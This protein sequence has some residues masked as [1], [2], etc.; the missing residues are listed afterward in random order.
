MKKTALSFLAH[1]DDAE[2]LCA[3]T[4]IRLREAGWDV[5][6]AT[7]TAA[8]VGR[9]RGQ[10]STAPTAPPRAGGGGPDLRDYH[11]ST[12][13]TSSSCS[14]ATI[15]KTLDLFRRVCRPL[16][17]TR[18][19][20]IRTRGGHHARAGASFAYGSRTSRLPG[21]PTR[22]PPL[23]YCDPIAGSTRTA[24]R[25]SRRRSDVTRRRT[26]GDARC[27]SATRVARATT[28]YDYRRDEAPRR[29][30]RHAG[31][32]TYARR[33]ATPDTLPR[34]TA[35]RDVQALTARCM[36]ASPMPRV[37]S[38]C[39]ATSPRTIAAGAP[40]S[41]ECYYLGRGL[42]SSASRSRGNASATC[43]TPY[44]NGVPLPVV[45]SPRRPA[46]RGNVR[47]DPRVQGSLRR[48][49]PLAAPLP[50]LLRTYRAGLRLRRRVAAAGWQRC[51][52]H[53]RRWRS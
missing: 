48:D 4:L 51:G 52:M 53:Q 1:P 13:A 35:R 22:P 39:S 10:W 40:R 8:T 24:S 32:A 16:F 33:S 42:S 6:I 47:I 46:G 37:Q 45:I 14:T 27:H 38:G 41:G 25:W 15:Q 28:A 43:A 23:Y 34:T 17:T 30:A 19:G 50:M 49:E 29:R 21:S 20:H 5:H 9:C 36:G 26:S 3:G 11:C 18:P 31:G 2:F 44:R 12:S 7:A